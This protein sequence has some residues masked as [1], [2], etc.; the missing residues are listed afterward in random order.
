MKHRTRRALG[1]GLVLAAALP[2]AAATLAER[3][4]D[5]KYLQGLRRDA[6]QLTRAAEP[7]ERAGEWLDVRCILHAHSSLSHDSHGT[8]EEIT[9]AARTTGVRAVF[10]TEHPTADRKWL[11]QG[12]AG[13]RDGVLF[14]PGAEL[15]DG[16]LLWR[17]QTAAWE[18]GMRAAEVLRALQGTDGVAFI[19]HPEMRKAEADWESLPPYTGMEIYNT[20]A[21]A[22][23]SDFTAVLG[24]V[25]S[26]NPF[27]LLTMLGTV[28]K[29]QQES[30]AAIFDEQTAVLKRWDDL[31]RKFFPTGRRVVGIAA[32]DSHQNVGLRFE[33]TEAGV[34]VRDALG[35]VLTELPKTK[36]PTFLL[37]RPG[38]TVPYQFDPYENSFRY[39][40]T[41][42]LAAEVKEG[43]LF[44]ALQRGRA[45]VAFDWMADPSGFRFTAQAGER[46]FEMGD[47]APVAAAP[48]LVVRPNM[49]CDIRVLRDGAPFLRQ[50]GR[51]LRAPITEPGVYR[52]ECWVSIGGET[53]PWIYSNP[54]YVT[55]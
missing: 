19:A 44:T 50:E 36:I 41:H 4:R 42:L 49:A 12:L 54:I 43:P 35:K 38:T 9:A 29:Y 33:V 45:Y 48:E 7:S 22:V 2:L 23:D 15:S 32:N 27:R 46:S 18:P 21:D 13:E 53:R 39:V 31:N 26:E 11:T 3:L 5:E 6:R 16:L 28:K 20:H 24:N 52:V 10:M 34:T 47:D 1:L 51:E 30:F 17:G 25:R 14:V 8:P 40:S 37:G 55:P